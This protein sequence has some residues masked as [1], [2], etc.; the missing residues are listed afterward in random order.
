MVPLD[1]NGSKWSKDDKRRNNS[2]HVL[3]GLPPFLAR[4]DSCIAHSHCAAAPPECGESKGSATV[5]QRVLLFRNSHWMSLNCHLSYFQTSLKH[6]PNISPFSRNVLISPELHPKLADVYFVVPSSSHTDA[7]E[8]KHLVPL[9]KMRCCEDVPS[10]EWM[11][12]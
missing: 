9:P 10:G 8:E 11:Y 6:S 3:I 12:L 4:P 2:S 1:A 5:K 7:A